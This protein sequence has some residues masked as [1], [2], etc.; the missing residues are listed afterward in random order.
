MSD[1]WILMSVGTMISWISTTVS[2]TLLL[3]CV[4][5]WWTDNRSRKKCSYQAATLARSAQW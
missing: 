4:A 5:V 2:R 3:R 1:V